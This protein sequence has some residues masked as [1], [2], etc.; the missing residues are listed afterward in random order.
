MPDLPLPQGD[1]RWQLATYV[2]DFGRLLTVGRRWL[3]TES[4]IACLSHQGLGLLAKRILGFQMRYRIPLT[5]A[6]A[7]TA[8]EWNEAYL[9]QA[10]VRRH[11]KLKGFS[12]WLRTP[13]VIP[14]VNGHEPV[15]PYDVRGGALDALLTLIT[16]AEVYEPQA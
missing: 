9:M 14:S 10:W 16:G 2:A 8:A 11:R 1:G 15:A 4:R 12:D 13:Q 5:N 6:M 3:P 7:F